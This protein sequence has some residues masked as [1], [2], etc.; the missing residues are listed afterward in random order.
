MKIFNLKK[1]QSFFLIIFFIA[2]FHTTTAAFEYIIDSDHS[3]ITF[4][5]GHLNTSYVLGRFND[6]SGNII[7]DENKLES[8]SVNVIIDPFSIDTGVAKRDFHL[9]TPD[10]LDIWKFPKITFVSTKI[11]KG[12]DKDTFEIA[13]KL[14]IKGVE[15]DVVL[16]AK[17][18]GNVIDHYGKERVAF[19][20][21]TAINRFDFNVDYNP[22]LKDNT[23]LI[24]EK[25]FIKIYIEAIK[26]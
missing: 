17:K 8:S 13:G 5:I 26:K 25:I 15:K 3:F 16:K 12:E 10:F 4:K 14:T 24:G 21:E 1:L 7:Y 19:K 23:P 2:I 9:R 20:A 6:F 11:T 22:K 18:L